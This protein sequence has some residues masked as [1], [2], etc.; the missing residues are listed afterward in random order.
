MI[1]SDFVADHAAA[2]HKHRADF[3]ARAEAQAPYFPDATI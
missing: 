2:H 3:V 1:A